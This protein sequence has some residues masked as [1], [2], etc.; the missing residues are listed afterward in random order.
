L[1]GPAEVVIDR[2]QEGKRRLNL[3]GGKSGPESEPRG[4]QGVNVE[5]SEK[6]GKT[7]T[8]GRRG[9]RHWLLR[10]TRKLT[11]CYFQGNQMPESREG[12]RGLGKLTKRG[13]AYIWGIDNVGEPTLPCTNGNWGLRQIFETRKIRLERG[14]GRGPVQAEKHWTWGHHPPMRRGSKRFQGDF[15]KSAKGGN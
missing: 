7:A 5:N 15:W 2:K 13:N 4:S 9:E 12:K 14:D 11:Y 3:Q 8:V 6:R 1:K 10:G